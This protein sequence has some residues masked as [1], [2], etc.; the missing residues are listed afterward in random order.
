[1]KLGRN[2]PCLCGSGK[3]YKHCCLVTGTIGAAAPTELVVRKLYGLI[4]DFG[5]R[6]WRF[7]GQ[8]YGPSLMEDAWTQFAGDHDIEYDE[9]SHLMQIFLPWLYHFWSPPADALG[10]DASL[11][12][13]TPTAAYLARKGRQVDPLLRRYLEFCLR[14]P[15]NFFEVMKSTPGERMLLR[16]MLSGTEHD[17]LERGL[18]RTT[19]RTD[20][21]FGQ[22]AHVDGMTL[23]GATG[24]FT[25]LP[26]AKRD[27]AELYALIAEDEG[28]DEV[29][30][31]VLRGHVLEL[32]DLYIEITEGFHDL[33]ASD[34]DPV[35]PRRLVYDLN[36]SPQAA[37]DALKHLAHDQPA[38]RLLTRAERDPAG[39]LL[40]VEFS[41]TQPHAGAQSGGDAIV[42]AS[43][44][45]DGPR[46]VAEV[47]SELHA[48]AV[49]DEIEAALGE[50]AEFRVTQ[51]APSRTPA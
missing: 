47:D 34:D 11:C 2:D 45:I 26:A 39:E 25:V 14:M 50:G 5:S 9:E 21:I 33:S 35:S 10:V 18:S 7:F 3:K 1:M 22:L 38:Q 29:A 46:L 36:V 19:D 23:L 28:G 42:M 41:W 40:R 16:D 27:I 13:M 44:A 37:F 32:V 8:A 49:A 15:F 24:E 4:D 43:I 48:D 17:V 6:M 30:D 31:A 51:V 12:G 20:I